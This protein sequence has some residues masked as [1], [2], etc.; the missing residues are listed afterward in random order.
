M[1]TFTIPRTQ[2][3]IGEEFLFAEWVGDEHYRAV[4][5]LDD[6]RAIFRHVEAI[7]NEEQQLDSSVFE[8]VPNGVKW[9]VRAYGYELYKID[10]GN[11]DDD[12]A[13]HVGRDFA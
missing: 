3:Y 10:N 6:E 5:E 1:R 7:R 12:E 11:D 4:F 8:D 13:E 9:V 2:V